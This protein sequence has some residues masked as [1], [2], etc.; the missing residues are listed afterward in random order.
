MKEKLNNYFKLNKLNGCHVIIDKTSN[1]KLLPSNIIFCHI[2]SSNNIE[3]I[4]ELLCKAYCLIF[5]N[6]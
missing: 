3:I 5:E 2:I 6:F 1:L 4:F